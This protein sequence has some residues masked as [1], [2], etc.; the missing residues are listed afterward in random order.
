ML[1]DLKPQDETVN[2]VLNWILTEIINPL[3]GL[4]AILSIIYF[5]V[6]VMQFFA[7]YKS[8]E[9]LSKLKTKLIWGMIGVIIVTS[10][11]T[12]ISIIYGARFR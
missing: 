4:A 12:I 6:I 2:T 11:W 3:L 9:D 1:E 7:A 8:G 5:V 10:S